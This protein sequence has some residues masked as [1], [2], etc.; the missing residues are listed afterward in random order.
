MNIRDELKN[1]RLAVD[2][3]TPHVFIRQ[4]LYQ[5]L[6]DTSMFDFA[7]RAHKMARWKK[8]LLKIVAILNHSWFEEL[9]FEE[10]VKFYLDRILAHVNHE[11]RSAGESDGVKKEEVH[12]LHFT[13]VDQDVK[14][15]Y[16]G[17]YDQKSMMVFVE[18]VVRK[19]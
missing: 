10:Q 3:D 2:V 7:L 13:V 12:L 18:S 16:V 11:R 8:W 14:P 5:E 6:L 1:D 17:I 4:D 19:V 15:L 9:V